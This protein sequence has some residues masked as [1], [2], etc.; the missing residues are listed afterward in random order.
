MHNLDLLYGDVGLA[1]QEQQV[2]VEA[3][4]RELSVGFVKDE[5]PIGDFVIMTPAAVQSLVDDDIHVYMQHG[6]SAGSAY[7]DA[8]YADVGVEFVDDFYLLASTARVLVK[9]QPFTQEQ[10]TLLREE[11]VIFSTQDAVYVNRDYL[12]ALNAK[13]IAALAMNFIEDKKGARMTD[14]I[15][16]ET[17]SMTAMNIAFSNFLLP[18]VTELSTNTRLRFALQKRPV[19]ME[20]VYCYAGYVC[21]KE[22]ADL[23]ELPYRDIVSL[24]WDLN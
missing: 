2:L 9:F 11:Q 4:V 1:T 22:M 17:L 18:L 23:L 3:P 15:L 10:V 19:L 13:H 16:T 14:R 20:S 24:C 21:H 8:D 5:E 12:E 6:F 7:S